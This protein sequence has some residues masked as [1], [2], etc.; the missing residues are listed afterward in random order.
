MLKK[1]V[2]DWINGGI[3]IAKTQKKRMIQLP[4]NAFLLPI[5]PETQRERMLF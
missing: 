1:S 4:M 5:I 2:G 3:K